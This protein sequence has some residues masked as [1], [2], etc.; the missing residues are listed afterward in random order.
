MMMTTFLRKT[1]LTLLLSTSLLSAS[2][3]GKP[4]DNGPLR[5]SDNQRFLQFTNGKPF[6]WLDNTS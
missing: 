2:A 3:A 5:V 4:W 1:T 6:F